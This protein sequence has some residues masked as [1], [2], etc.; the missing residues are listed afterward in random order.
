MLTCIATTPEPTI[1]SWHSVCYIGDG[2]QDIAFPSSTDAN[3]T[4]PS[5]LNGSRTVAVYHGFQNESGNLVH[6]STLIIKV[7]MDRPCNVTC[8]TTHGQ[9]NET[10]VQVLGNKSCN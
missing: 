9:R 3:T 2:G 4:I 1:L 7:L 8:E 6:Y 5:T 10:T